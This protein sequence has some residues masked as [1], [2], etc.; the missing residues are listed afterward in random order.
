ML[1]ILLLFHL[2]L[3]L[4]CYFLFKKKLC[5]TSILLVLINIIIFILNIT[6]CWNL[7]NSDNISAVVIFQKK[8]QENF[9]LIFTWILSNLILLALSFFSVK[10][11]V[12]KQKQ[13]KILKNCIYLIGIIEIIF[14]TSILFFKISDFLLFI[15]ICL[16]MFFIIQEYIKKQKIYLLTT[17]IILL[18]FT[19]YSYFTYEGQ[20]RL[21]IFLA[22]YVKEAYSIGIE[23]QKYYQE[24]NL[25]KYIPVKQLEIYNGK[26]GIIEVKN[27]LIIKF[28]NYKKY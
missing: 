11:A 4:E 15:Y 10:K 8:L 25:K 6:F 3:F 24:K 1:Y 21:Q 16:F 19:F 9:L 27:Y 20:A 12:R 7:F 14:F 22:G 26:M 23:E 5:K 28:G 13:N 17:S 2:L 18:I